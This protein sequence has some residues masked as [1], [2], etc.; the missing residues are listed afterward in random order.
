MTSIPS[1]EDRWLPAYR[2]A[3]DLALHIFRA[4]AKVGKEYKYSLAEHLR[5]SMTEIVESLHLLVSHLATDDVV[6]PC[7]RAAQRV[8]IQLRLLKDLRQVSLK[9]WGFLNAQLEVILNLLW[10]ESH[11]S[12]LVGA[13]PFQSSDPLASG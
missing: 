9:Q 2:H 3:Y 7:L 12:R 13:M 5:N 4:C 6:V 8:R 1:S 11:P 10:P